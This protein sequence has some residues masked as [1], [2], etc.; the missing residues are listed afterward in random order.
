MEIAEV[1][2]E[3]DFQ[4]LRRRAR[5]RPIAHAAFDYEQSWRRTEAAAPF[6][7]RQKRCF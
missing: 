2:G 7:S 3:F 5:A 4:D 6:M 1:L